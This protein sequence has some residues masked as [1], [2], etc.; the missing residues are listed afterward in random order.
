MLL[1]LK[2]KKLNAQNADKI[3]QTYLRGSVHS[4][5]ILELDYLNGVAIGSTRH[6]DLRAKFIRAADLPVGHVVNGKVKAV[7]KSGVL[8]RISDRVDGSAIHFNLSFKKPFALYCIY[9]Q[10]IH[11]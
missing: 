4:C 7:M 6:E 11:K 3:K 9:Q 10:Q 8:V 5:C 1:L 2:L